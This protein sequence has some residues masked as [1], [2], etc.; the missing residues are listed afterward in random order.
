MEDFDCGRIPIDLTR[1]G[2]RLGKGSFGS[3]YDLDGRY[4]IKVQAKGKTPEQEA[5]NQAMA[6][7]EVTLAKLAH[8]ATDRTVE[9]KE[10][11][12]DGKTFIAMPKLSQT[13]QNYITSVELK[14]IPSNNDFR[15]LEKIAQ[16]LYDGLLELHNNGIA[17]QDIHDQN[18]MLDEDYN[19]YFID[20][21]LGCTKDGVPQTNR[22]LFNTYSGA[23][24]FIPKFIT[25]S[26]QM[27]LN[28]DNFLNAKMHDLYSLAVVFYLMNKVLWHGYGIARR[29]TIANHVKY[30]IYELYENLMDKIYKY[31]VYLDNRNIRPPPGPRQSVGE[32]GYFRTPRS[33]SARPSR[34]SSRQPRFSSTPP[35]SGVER[36]SSQQHR[37]SC[38]RPYKLVSTVKYDNAS[39][40]RRRCSGR[41][42]ELQTVVHYE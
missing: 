24:Q 4:A 18:I 16:Q 10:C 34:S 33:S 19:P 22:C 14:P 42:R 41:P 15:R 30:P 11:K 2:N 9:A 7:M 40:S 20:F 35:I 28:E 31:S 1:L 29:A 17:L 36:L 26:G 23:L 38:R 32:R 39:G 37:K 3:V 25:R 6:N 12:R 27:D 8:K 21:G 5:K 13:L